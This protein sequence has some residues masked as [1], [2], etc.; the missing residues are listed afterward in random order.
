MGAYTFLNENKEKSLAL[1]WIYPPRES[2][3][4]KLFLKK[5]STFVKFSQ[6]KYPTLVAI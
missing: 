3:L 5:S 2:Q 1:Y 6:A 4:P